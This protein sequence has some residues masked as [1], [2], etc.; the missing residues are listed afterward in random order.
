MKAM[1]F[2]AGE[3]LTNRHG[4]FAK[5]IEVKNGLVHF[6]GW[7]PKKKQAQDAES[8]TGFMN[9]FGIMRALGKLDQITNEEESGGKPSDDDSNTGGNDT[10]DG[11]GDGDD[12]DTD[13]YADFKNDDLKEALKEAGLT[14]SGNRA[15]LIARLEEN[16]IELV[17]E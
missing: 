4:Q 14:V 17:S 8:S 10:G 16:N 11:D 2:K 9:A 5:V 12:T 13:P 7:F 1:K 6:A 15:E 3:V